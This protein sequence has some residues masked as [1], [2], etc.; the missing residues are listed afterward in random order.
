MQAMITRTCVACGKTYETFPSHKPTYCSRQCA[1]AAKRTGSEASCVVCGKTFWRFASSKAE[2]CSKSCA[3]T[4][5]N[6]TDANPALRRDISGSKNPMFGKGMVGAD[7]PMFGRTGA[8]SP[9]WKGG[10]RVRRDGYTR[11]VV[12]SDHPYPSE[13]AC[14]GTRYI[15]EHRFVMEQHVGRYLMPGEVVHHRDGNPRNNA[16]ENLELF[17]NQTDHMKAHRAL[18]SSR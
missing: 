10:R 12:P 11:V 1:G 14:T 9:R 13:I 6:R 4:K 3:A 5:R 18:A 16:I 15:L 2:C 17:A 8:N 7:N